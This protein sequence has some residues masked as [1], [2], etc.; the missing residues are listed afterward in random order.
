MTEKEWMNENEQ[1]S[2]SDTRH[3]CR[4]LRTYCYSYS[5]H[6]GPKNIS[7][8]LYRRNSITRGWHCFM[9]CLVVKIVDIYMALWNSR[10]WWSYMPSSISHKALKKLKG[11]QIKT[12]SIS[13]GRWWGGQMKLRNY[14]APVTARYARQAA[15]TEKRT[16][17]SCLDGR[18]AWER[19]RQHEH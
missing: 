2:Y 6:D 1:F 5:D 8:T 14:T 13:S 12:I 3:G 10:E 11:V 17:S 16:H 9:H 19:T 18:S 15:C 7:D 4:N